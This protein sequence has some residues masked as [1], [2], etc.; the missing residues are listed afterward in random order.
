[1]FEE[2]SNKLNNVFRKIKGQGKLSETNIKDA[3]RDIRR[4]LLEADVNFKVAKKFIEKVQEK[5][6][7]QE[8]VK[9][10]TPG[11]QIVKIVNDELT[12]LM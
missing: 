1:M 12:H 4:G 3:L 2:I 11:Q 5:A 6:I 7:G 9:S 10:V 8:V